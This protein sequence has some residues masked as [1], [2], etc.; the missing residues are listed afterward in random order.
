MERNPILDAALS[1]EDGLPL[2]LQL[3]S[4]TR[5]CIS[6]GLLKPG[7]QLPSEAELC[8]HFNISRSTV[9]QALKELEEQGLVLRRQGL[10]SFVAEPKLYRRSE[11]IYSFTSEATAMGRKPGSRLLSFEII[12]PSADIRRLM[13]LRD[14]SVEV[15]RFTRIRLVD[16]M[17]LMLETSYYP[18]Y[19]Y[20]GLTRE[21]VQTH[22]FYSLLLERDVLL[23]HGC[24]MACEGRA[25]LFTAPSGTGKTTHCRLWLDRFPGSHVLNGDKP[26]LRIEEER[27]FACG[28]PWQ[29]KERYG[30]NEILPLEA[31]CFL[32]RDTVNHIAPVSFH[33]AF[34]ALL[35]Q[36]HRPAGGA[37]M[38]K[39]LALLEKLGQR[40]RL[41]RLGCNREPEAAELSF[42]T[43]HG[44][45]TP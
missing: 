17:P 6:S 36:T 41:Y 3:A 39:T 37:A 13:E 2:Y 40:T 38:L 31:I 4:L 26:L 28:T 9:R 18:C 11:N 27:V 10:G 19:I 12:R 25:Y 8:R 45:R 30:C 5:R 14:E 21:L 15:Y 22:S 32:E 1:A 34:P 7:D 43:M 44:D 33:D 29:G 16:E 20:P 42:T 24:V 23:F 35:A